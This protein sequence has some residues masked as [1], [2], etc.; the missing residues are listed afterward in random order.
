MNV[1]RTAVAHAR[2]LPEQRFLLVLARESAAI[3][4]L[5][6]NVAC[7]RLASYAVS[8]TVWRRELAVLQQRWTGLTQELRQHPVLDLARRVGV[9]DL[10]RAWLR[11]AVPVRHAWSEVFRKENI[12]G[13]LSA[14]DSNPYTR[15]PLIVAQQ[16]GKAAVACHHGALDLRMAF[17]LPHADHYLAQGPME[18][19]YLLR[20]CGL[21]PDSILVGDGL[22]QQ[23][24]PPATRD[25]WQP[26][27]VFFSD[28]Y[29]TD[30]WRAE[31]VFAEV[32]PPLCEIARRS[33]RNLVV[34]L[35]PFESLRQRWEMLLHLLAPA[36][37]AV[38]EIIADPLSTEML[39]KIWF[40][41]TVESTTALECV[42]AGVPAFLMGWLRHAYSGYALQ[43][44][45]FGA[46]QLLDSVTDLSR[47]PELLAV[48]VAADVQTKLR[49]PLSRG[50][51]LSAL[52]GASAGT[53]RM[54]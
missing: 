16:R 32:L 30:V 27:I 10:G 35:H 4:N 49:R 33:G 20:V 43:F 24:P 31:S 21:G 45:K 17:K 36:D 9:L 3:P 50:Q 6:A 19:D 47:I 15:I 7:T 38:I 42:C 18:E 1:S 12:V 29:E 13:C 22:P 2:S 41:V 40:A 51:L 25:G 14:D 34:K 28:S 8:P 26:W 11:L 39:K 37:F 44:A 54:G 48:P 23:S 53:A 5:P 52:T 46:G